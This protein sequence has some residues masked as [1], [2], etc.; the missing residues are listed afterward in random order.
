VRC[1]VLHIAAAPSIAAYLVVA[2]MMSIVC[3]TDFMVLPPVGAVFGWHRHRVRPEG[4]NGWMVSEGWV[5]LVGHEWIPRTG[6]TRVL[7]HGHGHPP[8]RALA[9]SGES[10]P[11]RYTPVRRSTSAGGEA[12]TAKSSSTKDDARS[13]RSATRPN[14]SG[15]VTVSVHDAIGLAVVSFAGRSSVFSGKNDAPL[16][17]WSLGLLLTTLGLLGTASVIVARKDSARLMPQL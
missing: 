7:F 15:P 12:K 14:R 16:A 17:I 13:T 3:L 2:A 1:V 6:H 10:H 9:W 5:L 4:A 8:S 11:F